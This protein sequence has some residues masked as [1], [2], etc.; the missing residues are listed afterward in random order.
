M[1]FELVL[2]SILNGKVFLEVC[3][4]CLVVIEGFGIKFL[5]NV[6][7]RFFMLLFIVLFGVIKI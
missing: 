2:I 4:N 1:S 7:R 6:L 3:L 5:C